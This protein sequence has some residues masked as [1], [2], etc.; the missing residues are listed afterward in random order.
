MPIEELYTRE[1]A[2]LNRRLER[3]LGSA[4][5]AED[6]SQEAFVRT[7]RRAPGHLS[8]DERAAWLNRTATNLALDELRRRRFAGPELDSLELP[9][10]ETPTD[11]VLAAR[12]ALARMTPHERMILLLRFELGLSHAEIGALLDVSPEAARKRAERARRSFAA[13]LRRGR[14]E[15]RPRILLYARH[16]FDSYARWLEQA[17]ADVRAPR[18]TAQDSA[19]VEREL[20]A[21]DAVVIG[22]SVTD[23][24][25]AMYGEV[26]RTDLHDPDLGGDVRELRVLRSALEQD[27]PVVGVCR[28]HQLLNVALGGT[29]FQDLVEDGATSRQHWGEVHS[30]ETTGGTFMRRLLGRG[31]EVL[32]EH[33]QGTR[34]LGR[35]LRVAAVSRDG[36]VEAVELPGRRLTVGLQWHPEA[37]ASGEAGQRVAAA[38]VEAARA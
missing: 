16:D 5:L 9:T 8:A 29:L 36:V 10:T 34:R 33:H 19:A 2:R 27:I 38:L 18:A 30:V 23:M 20:A 37:S 14:T 25:P 32:S 11:D 6:L 35:G 21:S 1:R 31:P 13:S 3:M 26:P 12:E 17:G 15:H 7:W 24:H 4:A 28:G 22:G